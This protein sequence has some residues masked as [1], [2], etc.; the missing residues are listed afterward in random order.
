[1]PDLKA[2]ADELGIATHVRFAGAVGQDD[3][4]AYY[5]QAD[6]MVVSSF[7][8]GVPVVLMEAMAKEVAVTAPRLAGIPELVE[9]G[10]SGF[11]FPPGSREALTAA[12]ARAA[13][14]RAGLPEMGRAGRR[15][16]VANFSIAQTGRDMVELWR[17]YLPGNAADEDWG[18]AQAGRATKAAVALS[19]GARDSRS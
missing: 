3:I 19:S 7:M 1:L 16:V 17:R 9:D 13:A 8:E 2:L 10:V 12:L 6:L 15:R 5:D 11:L 14:G 4:G 18:K